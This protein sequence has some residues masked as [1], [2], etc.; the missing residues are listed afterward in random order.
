MA[1]FGSAR[2]NDQAGTAAVTESEGSPGVIAVLSALTAG[3]GV[4][5][6][7]R[8]SRE[9]AALVGALCAAEITATWQ[10]GLSWRSRGRS[11]QRQGRHTRPGFRAPDI[12]DR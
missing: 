9:G 6:S 4:S 1:A 3:S 7:P 11:R 12:V 5:L 2:D 8:L 10:A